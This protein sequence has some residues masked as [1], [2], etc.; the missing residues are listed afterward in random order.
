[1]TAPLQEKTLSLKSRMGLGA[2]LLVAS[3]AYLWLVVDPRLIYDGFGTIVLNVPVFALDWQSLRDALS[4]AGGLTVYTY[5]FL[6]QGFCYAWLGA[7]LILLTALCVSASARLHYV[8]ASRSSATLLACF[9]ALGVLMMYNHHD[10]PLEVCLTL[11]L[12][13]LFSWV[14]EKMP[15]HRALR[16][17]AFCLLSG[18]SYWLGGT[19]AAGI[20]ALM[21]VIYL[22][23][24][25][26]WLAALLALPATAGIIRILADSVFYLSPKQAFLTLTP[27]C[28]DWVEGLGLFSRV[29]IL[30]LYAFVPVTVSFLCL[31]R[32][33]PA[34]R[35]DTRRPPPRP[36]ASRK[37]RSA[38]ARAPGLLAYARRLARPAVPVAVLVVG[39]YG[40]YDKIHSRIV[41]M[42]ALAQRG[43]WPEVL[44]QAARL[45][46]NVYSIYAN[47]DIDRALY[48]TGRLGYD[49]FCFPQNPHAFLLTH[50]EDESCMTQLKM[51]DT[52]TELGNVDLAEKLASEFL[53]AKGHLPRVLEKLAWIN[54]VKGQ[55][56]TA[57]VYLQTLKKDLIYRRR[58]EALLKGLDRG[59]GPAEAA[60]IRRVN[61]CIRRQESGR[62]NQESIEE[63]LTGLLEQNPHN[64]MAFEYLM[65]CYLL[66]GRVDKVTANVKYLA[67]F[68]YREIPT[69][70]EEAML[71]CYAAQRRPLDPDNPVVSRRTIERY[72]RFVQLNNSLR[73]Y[74]PEPVVQQLTRE[75]GTSYFFY[76]RFTISR[77]T[78]NPR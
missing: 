68:G 42:N 69:L 32:L 48:H 9:P 19:G 78:P 61:S 43:C 59:F 30:L 57:W 20:F 28:R 3:Y 45:P 31:W 64:R 2:I 67:G 76:Y 39:L 26:A 58:A 4:L 44:Q 53:V 17:V 10:H 5:G 21:T 74:N 60:E 75:F 54:I 13:L 1:M 36:R 70:Y 71:I 11:S 22:L 46:G 62:L 66:A 14:F 29:L 50:E 73:T 16:T 65:A 52:F 77:S 24:R 41:V 23:F 37:A 56:D 25:R 55:E 34:W 47:H 12:G 40:S 7:L 18:I 27:F 72:E 51:C 49:M 33:A 15:R 63:M 35:P 8:R 6:S 38:R